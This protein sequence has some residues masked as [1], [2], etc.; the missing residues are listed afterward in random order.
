MQSKFDLIKKMVADID[1]QFQLRW[2]NFVNLNDY[3]EC[4]N[5]DQIQSIVQQ[6]NAL[7][8]YSLDTLIR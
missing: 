3:E 6:R 4:T 5:L 7:L 1:V 8:G 2:D